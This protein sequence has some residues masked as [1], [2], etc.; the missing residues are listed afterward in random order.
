MAF[1][2]DPEI[3]AAMAPRMAALADITLPA[4]GDVAGRRTMIEQIMAD[5][6]AAQPMPDDVTTTDFHATAADGAAIL[7]RWYVKDG[8][9]PGPA[10]LYIHGGGMIL[11]NVGLYDGPV[12]RYVS[13]S[14]TSLLSVEYRYAPEHPHPIPVEDCYAGLQW[15]HAH[16]AELGV[17]PARIA[18][19]GDSGGG[20]LAAG[21]AILAR[22]RGGPAI[23][24]QIL[25]YPMLDDRNTVP[26]PELVPFL[27][28]SYDD[29]VTGW[30]ALL[31]DAAGGPDVSPYAAP[32]RLTDATGLPPAYIEVGQLD[33]FRDEDIAYAVLL[34]RAGVEV[35]L[36]LHPGA[37]HAFEGFAFAS[38]VAKRSAADRVRVLGAV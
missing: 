3:A 26:D 25:V 34:G 7:L 35:E 6:S 12:A 18:I 22:D 14:G 33:I 19:M 31:G 9:Q 13:R 32:A 36:H 2:I 30:G 27:A 28:W 37:P 21:L 5:V 10:A 17:D 16:A 1:Q 20:G 29:N 8:A 15:L 4:A 11:G 24:R 38:A 23:A